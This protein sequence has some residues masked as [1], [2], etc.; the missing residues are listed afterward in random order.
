MTEKEKK[1]KEAWDVVRKDMQEKIEKNKDERDFFAAI[2]VT[3]KNGQLMDDEEAAEIDKKMKDCK[4]QSE[5]V[6]HILETSENLPK[7]AALV[8]K[9]QEAKA[10]SLLHTLMGAGK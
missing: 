8:S 6:S 5:L 3:L 2:G 10:M 7:F 4:L 9:M 1:V